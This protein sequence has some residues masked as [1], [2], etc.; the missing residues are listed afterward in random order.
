METRAQDALG[1]YC[2]AQM[3][4]MTREE[5]PVRRLGIRTV[6]FG[7]IFIGGS[8]L[9][10]VLFS[11]MTNNPQFLGHLL[12]EG[13]LIAGWVALWYAAEIWLFEIWENRSERQ[14]YERLGRIQLHFKPL[15]TTTDE[16]K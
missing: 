9:L 3:Q 15:S 6:V 10:S 1:G 13:F 4:Q 2:R 7:L 16:T 11:D 5:A 8:L 14:Y 12:V